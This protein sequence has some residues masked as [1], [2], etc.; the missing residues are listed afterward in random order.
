MSR[1][2]QISHLRA[3]RANPRGMALINALIVVAAL[4]AV[5]L[6]LLA[7]TDQVHQR[8]GLRLDADQ[9]EQYLDAAEHLVRQLVDTVGG[10]DF[11]H[12]GQSWAIPRTGVA[13]DRGSV[14]W[15]IGDLQ[16]RFNINW[17]LRTDAMG[18]AARGAFV[19]LARAQDVPAQVAIRIIDAAGSQGPFRDSAF[20]GG[21]GVSSPPPLPLVL[22]QV[23]RLVTGAGDGRLD[24]LLPLVSALPPESGLNINTVAPE[25]LAAFVPDLSAR[26]LGAF[27]RHRRER[28]LAAV[29]DFLAWV[30]VVMGEEPALALQDLS[31]TTGS[32]WFDAR[33]VA[34]LDTIVLRRSVTLQRP[35]EAGHSAIVL[36]MPEVD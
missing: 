22:P 9:A 29:G 23:L 8:I 16:G 2:D 21:A 28:P 11:V 34:R 31:L 12:S 27:E 33:L 1:K 3:T 14:G 36:S 19:R 15:Q 5:S 24:R 20:G 4:A 7:R 18:E 6:A 30:G 17:V 32:E 25:V 13:I 35:E 26:D 10:D